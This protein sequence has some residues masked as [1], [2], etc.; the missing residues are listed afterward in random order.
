MGWCYY[1]GAWDMAVIGLA[2][3]AAGL[4][5][6]L[7]E[8]WQKQPNN[9]NAVKEKR[10]PPTRLR[11]RVAALGA[12]LLVIFAYASYEDST[13]T[14][15][16]YDEKGAHKA[17]KEACRCTT[18]SCLRNALEHQHTLFRPPH[19]WQP[20]SQ[21]CGGRN[22]VCWCSSAFLK[23]DV[24][25]HRQASFSALCAPFSSYVSTV[26]VLSS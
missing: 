7:R 13:F 22:S 2:I 12:A 18:T 21:K 4:G 9:H 25:V 6:G 11:G 19:F 10:R 14:V 24:D 16:T 23:Q 17:E 1:P 5:L 20:P 26:K 15:D 8:R 3:A